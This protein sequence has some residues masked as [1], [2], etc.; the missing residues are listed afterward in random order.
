MNRSM[1]YL[2]INIGLLW[3]IQCAVRLAAWKSRYGS[4][5]GRW[6]EIVGTMEAFCSLA[7]V[8]HIHPDWT[9]PEIEDQGQ[10]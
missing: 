2:I 7:V 1:F 9:Y 8:A 10:K 3:D 6:L 4:R 5:V